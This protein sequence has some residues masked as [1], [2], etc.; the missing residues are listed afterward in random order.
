MPTAPR[1]SRSVDALLGQSRVLAIL[2]LVVLMA[3]VISDVVAGSFWVRHALL[4][5]L[6]GSVI[7][8]LLSVAV[9]DEVLE[10]R[11]RR[12]WKILAQYVMFELVRNARMTWSG[13]LDVA[14][15]LPT[16]TM[17]TDMLTL[18]VA[19]VRDTTALSAALNASANDGDRRA[20]MH[21]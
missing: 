13:T 10:R 9:I 12:R 21:S 6:V 2:A 7:V 11:R 17:R 20:E 15:M 16:G 8:V 3:G 19:A 14:G 18:G 5:S 4:A 1:R